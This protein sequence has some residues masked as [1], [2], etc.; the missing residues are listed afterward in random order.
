MKDPPKPPP[1]VLPPSTL[2]IPKYA[3]G[4]PGRQVKGKMTKEKRSIDRIIVAVFSILFT[5]VL[6]ICPSI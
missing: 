5:V 1:A 4:L 2:R 3:Q 6:P